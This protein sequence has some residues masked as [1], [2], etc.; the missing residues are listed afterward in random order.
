[1]A[2]QHLLHQEM[3]ANTAKMAEENVELTV[4]FPGVYKVEREKIILESTGKINNIREECSGSKSNTVQGLKYLMKYF[5][6]PVP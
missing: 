3:I 5:Y 4:I 6:Y 2:H 1:M